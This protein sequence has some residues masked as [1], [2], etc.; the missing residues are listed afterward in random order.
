M[1]DWLKLLSTIGV[2]TFLA[3]VI[4]SKI[5]AKQHT[6]HMK[7]NKVD[8]KKEL[9]ENNYPLDTEEGF[10]IFVN[11]NGSIEETT[12]AGSVIMVYNKD[13]EQFEYYSDREIPYRFLEVVARKYVLTYNC[14][15]LYKMEEPPPVVEEPP[16]VEEEVVEEEVVAPSEKNVF[17]VYKSYNK[18]DT[19]IK[20]ANQIIN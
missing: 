13:E 1:P 14:K 5:Y 20:K 17:V 7:V 9:Y 16:A 11:E 15:E 12:P 8:D 6:S 2:G 18:Q 19:N 4:V 3:V 10:K